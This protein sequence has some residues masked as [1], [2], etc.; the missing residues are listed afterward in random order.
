MVE[1]FLWRS[2]KGGLRGV[3]LR[4]K[5]PRPPWILVMNHHSFFDGHLVWLLGQRGG[6]PLS[7]LVAEENLRAFPV[8]RLAG[9]L[10]AHRLREA[11]RRLGRGEGLALFPEGEMRH[12]GAL[13]PL[14]PGA[15][16]LAEKARV[17][18]LPVAARVVLRGFEHPEAFLWAGPL[19]PPPGGDLEGALGGLVEGLDTLLQATHP[20]AIPEGFRPILVG[21]RSL[22]ERLKPLVEGVKRV[23]PRV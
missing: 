20:R 19:L 3:Y 13:G 21:R 1:A 16:Y 6:F 12:P 22:E 10:E 8:L 14:K 7:L 18:I 9:A 11:L 23:W 15:V 2:L 17:P 5:V 4:G